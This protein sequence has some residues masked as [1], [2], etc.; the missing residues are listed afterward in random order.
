MPS[1]TALL[2]HV[3]YERGG[4]VDFVVRLGG[5]VLEALES[6]F[7]VLWHREMHLLARVIPLNGESTVSFSFF[8]DRALIIFLDCLQEVLGVLFSDVFDSKIVD[9]QGER[10]GMPLV[11]P[12]TRSCFA[13]RIAMFLQS[14][15]EEF[16]CDDPRLGEPVHALAD[17]AVHESIRGCDIAQFV[18]L[19]DVVRHVREF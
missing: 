5:G 17:L 9:D 16:L 18:V 14:F 10:N 1:H 13:L 6:I 19:D 4:A 15:G 12:Q 8:F 3:S 7:D 11:L 2:P